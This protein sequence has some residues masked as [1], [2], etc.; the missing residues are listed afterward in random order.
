MPSEGGPEGRGV[1]EED[2]TGVWDSLPQ[3]GVSLRGVGVWDW[4]SETGVS[5]RGEARSLSRS[6]K[7]E[8]KEEGEGDESRMESR[9]MLLSVRSTAS[10]ACADRACMAEGCWCAM[11]CADSAPADSR[12]APAVPDA[13][14]C[15]GALC[16]AWWE[17]SGMRLALERADSESSLGRA[18]RASS[19]GHAHRTCPSSVSVAP[20][21][22]G[23]PE[24]YSPLRAPRAGPVVEPRPLPHPAGMPAGDPTAEPAVEPACVPSWLPSELLRC[25]PLS[26]GPQPSCPATLGPVYE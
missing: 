16:S 25:L 23:V 10:T 3:W 14:P 24:V 19:W 22:G 2:L 21:S 8:E 11:V 18:E 12:C 17:G 7:E 26:K 9:L 13:D 6:W 20:S 5:G 15:S 4:V 1:P